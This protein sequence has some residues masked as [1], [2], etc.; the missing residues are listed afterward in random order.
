MNIFG[1]ITPSITPSIP[2][3]IET[4]QNIDRSKVHT[5]DIH[6]SPS[7]RSPIPFSLVT[8]TNITTKDLLTHDLSIDF[9]PTQSS[10][11]LLPPNHV[12]NQREMIITPSTIP[13]HTINISP[14]INDVT[15][16]PLHPRY[17]IPFSVETPMAYLIIRP[18]MLPTEPSDSRQTVVM[19]VFTDNIFFNKSLRQ[20]DT[21][22]GTPQT[23]LLIL[24]KL[25][26]RH[27]QTLPPALPRNSLRHSLNTPSSTLLI[28]SL[29]LLEHSI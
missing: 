27:F 3:S 22:S 13:A 10:S 19:I 16:F 24:L 28:I 20:K 6:L 4:P 14:T 17:P 12:E 1:S 21:C 29:A 2:L 15:G 9:P 26:L 18:D 25:P 11:T 7:L 5:K 23:L 8:P